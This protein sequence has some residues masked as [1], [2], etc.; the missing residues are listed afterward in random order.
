MQRAL[1]RL[2]GGLCLGPDAEFDMEGRSDTGLAFVK[3][4]T[5]HLPRQLAG[6]MQAKARALGR[7]LT[8][9]VK[10][11]EAAKD[12]L[13]H[14]IRDAAPMIA[15][16]DPDPALVRRQPA[17]HGVAYVGEFHRVRDQIVDHLP[18]RKGIAQDHGRLRDLADIQPDAALMRVEAFDR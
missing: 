16:R 2:R 15:D 7:F 14:P 1:G 9:V 13:L 10:L 8:V 5:R 6:D 4:I 3:Q 11:S 12:P 18:D 17:L